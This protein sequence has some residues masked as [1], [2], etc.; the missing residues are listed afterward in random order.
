MKKHL[1]TISL[2][3]FTATT[4]TACIDATFTGYFEFSQ[5]N[6]PASDYLPLNDTGITACGDHAYDGSY[7]HN[8]DINCAAV[9]TT[10]TNAGTEVAYGLD[11]VPAG[12]DAVYG[13]DVTDNDDSDG[14]AGFSFTK[15]DSN[16]AA[17]ADQGQDYATEQWHCVLDNVTGRMWEVKT[18][19]GGL[20]DKDHTYSWYN[21]TGINDGGH[22]GFDDDG[23]CAGG[24]GCDTE[25]YVAGV[26]AANLC[27]F[28]DWRLPTRDELSSLVSNDRVLPAI[29][30]LYFPNTA[31]SDYWAA[32][33]DAENPFF[34]W[35]VTFDTGNS[36]AANKNTDFAVRL[37]RTAE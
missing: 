6:T 3:V 28:N 21:S 30:T 15:L 20:Q 2:S 11:P 32:S 12:Q 8:N 10:Q 35:R 37:V 25:K 14:H 13:R 26:N 7:I 5:A 16:G 18:D 17:L 36:F 24:S 9:G 31:S 27:G 33:P 19:D 34:A 1:L 29:D 4:L 22:I 23:V